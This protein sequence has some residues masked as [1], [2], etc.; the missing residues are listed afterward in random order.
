[1]ELL[2]L[3]YFR[4]AAKLENFSKVARKNMVPQP[5]ISKTIKKLEDELGVTLFDR[6][7]RQISLN[8]NG[9]FFLEHIDKALNDIDL[10]VGH[11]SKPVKNNIIVYP[12]AGG[13]FVSLLIADFLSSQNH[14]FVS[15]VNKGY[16][17]NGGIYDFTFM[18]PIE[19]MDEYNYECLMDEEIVL[20]V[21]KSNPLSRKKSISIHDL[22]DYPFVGYYKTIGIRDFTDEFCEKTAGFTPNVVFETG[23]YAALQYMIEKDKGLSLVP[24]LL[25]NI[26]HTHDVK[27]IPLKEKLYRKLLI[28][29]DK[30]HS[31]SKEEEFFLNFSKDWFKSQPSNFR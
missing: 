1:M 14:L 3:R 4:D 29:W 30:N 25:F 31:L 27:L 11:F 12:Q 16:L 28:A 9:Q 21:S 26:Q 23:D 8:K 22:K 19:N 10:A 7:G 13:R 6:N 17:D 15:N 24:Y 5:S 20:A 18:Q 2:Q